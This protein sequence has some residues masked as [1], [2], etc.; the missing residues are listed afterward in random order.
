MGKREKGIALT[1][2][3]EQS[4]SREAEEHSKG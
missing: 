2:A 3:K 4:R 1:T